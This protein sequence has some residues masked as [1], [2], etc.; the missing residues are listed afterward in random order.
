MRIRKHGNNNDDLNTEDFKC[1]NCGCEFSAD[2]D[3]YYVEK[4]TTFTS[5][6]STWY[7]F[8]S[9]VTDIYACS[10]PECHKIV[11][12]TKQRTIENPTITLTNSSSTGIGDKK[13]DVYA[14]R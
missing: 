5:S 10:C 6:A 9:T 12:K 4:G 14:D 8:S 3:E 11:T 2:Y 13:K 7:V 1:E